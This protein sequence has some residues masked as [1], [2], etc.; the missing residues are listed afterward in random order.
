MKHAELLEL[1]PEHDP[2]ET[3][4][5][6]AVRGLAGTQELAE[7]L[8]AELA[9]GMLIGLCGPLGAGKTE[10]VRFLVQ[11]LGCPDTVTSPTFVLESVYPLP[12]PPASGQSGRTSALEEIRHWDL[13]RLA[14]GALPEELL[15]AKE[16]ENAVTL[17]EWCERSTALMD[18]LSLK[19]VIALGSL[20]ESGEQSRE[21]LI[22][23]F[24]PRFRRPAD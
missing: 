22:S 9:P 3:C 11:A 4:Y 17:V 15:Q 1:P 18:L 20:E 16:A 5:R 24:D 7:K 10:F 14:D 23:V 12:S 8:S 2:A 21:F 19:I 6:Y 13:Y